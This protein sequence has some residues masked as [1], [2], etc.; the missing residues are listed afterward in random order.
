MIVPSL[1]DLYGEECNILY[2][3]YWAGTKLPPLYFDHKIASLNSTYEA[4]YKGVVPSRPFTEEE[5]NSAPSFIPG[6]TINLLKSTP[7]RSII[8]QLSQ[9]HQSF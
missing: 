2:D 8:V 9:C 4:I 1:F 6:P 5:L 7:S 3:Y